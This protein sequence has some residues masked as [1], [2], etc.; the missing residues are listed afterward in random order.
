MKCIELSP[1]G[2]YNAWEPVRKMELNS[3]KFREELGHKVLFED[4]NIRLWLIQLE[5]KERVGFTCLKG[6]FQ[7]ISHVQGFAVSHRDD[8][9]IVLIQYK[10]GDVFR[11]SQ[12]KNGEQVWDLENIGADPLEFVVIQDLNSEE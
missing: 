3:G 8:G 2:H 10:K 1:K 12:R 11:Y 5:P 6:D 4:G 7:V 9:E